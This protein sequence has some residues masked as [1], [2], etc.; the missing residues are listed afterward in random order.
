MDIQEVW[1]FIYLLIFIVGF[2]FVGFLCVDFKVCHDFTRSWWGLHFM[3]NSEYWAMSILYRRYHEK[4]AEG[5]TT[6]DFVNY[7][8][9]RYLVNVSRSKWQFMPEKSKFTFIEILSNTKFIDEYMNT[10]KYSYTY[11]K[12]VMSAW[13][14]L[15]KRNESELAQNKDIFNF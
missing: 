3:L 11:H 15:K 1:E 14:D 9:Q 12:E 2:L 8:T 6:Y 4:K 10:D 5:M 13:E 7:F